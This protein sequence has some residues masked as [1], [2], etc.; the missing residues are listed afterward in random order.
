MGAE[1]LQ[2]AFVLRH[3]RPRQQDLSDDQPKY[4][5][6]CDKRGRDEY[7]DPHWQLVDE[8]NPVQ[9]EFPAPNMVDRH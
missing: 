9:V 8:N 4:L 6:L 5:V 7:G 2:V 1:K 3:G